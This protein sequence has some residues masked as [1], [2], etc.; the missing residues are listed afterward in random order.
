MRPS[1]LAGKLVISASRSMSLYCYSIL[2]LDPYVRCGHGCIYCYTR[3]LPGYQSIP[4]PLWGYPEA[5]DK[6]LEAS[7]ETPVI[8]MPFRMSALTDPLQPIERKAKLG[9]DTLKIALKHKIPV[10][11][12]TKSTLLA[13]PPWLD[14]VKEIAG[15][16]KIVA[17]LT[18]TTTDNAISKALEPGAPRPEERLKAVEKL[19]SEGVPV[20]VRLQPLIPGVNDDPESLE[21]LI[22]QVKAAGALQV[23]AEYYRFSSW[24]DVDALSKALAPRLL[25][26]LKSKSLWEKYP[27]GSH[28]RPRKSYRLAKYRLIR[29]LASRKGLLFS[30]CRE[31]FLNLDTASNCCGINFMHGYRLRPTLR[32]LLG[33]VKGSMYV[34]KEELLS[35]P[36]SSL[37]K[38]LLEHY[39]YLEKYHRPGKTSE[40]ER[41]FKN[42][43]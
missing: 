18:L 34:A 28:K 29:D 35:I 14:V 13:E 24:N 39:E 7:S 38:G 3:L 10:L 33:N 40:E 4:K 26:Y 16:K 9:L 41:D 11:L 37:R 42:F 6:V 22:D 17:Q 31:E 15:E 1:D 20:V 25:I 21:N 43:P 12:S 27:S 2:R 19:S 8:Q 30:L 32:E 36:F 23:I 5:L